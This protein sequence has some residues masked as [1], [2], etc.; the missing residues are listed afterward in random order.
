MVL[1]IDAPVM[2]GVMMPYPGLRRN[3]LANCA[4]AAVSNGSVETGNYV[5][6]LGCFRA[7]SSIGRA[8]DS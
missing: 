6:M 1:T 4:A 5:K 8:T 7:V 3:R 2:D